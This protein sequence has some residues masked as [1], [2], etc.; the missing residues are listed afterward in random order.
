[1]ETDPSLPGVSDAADLIK[2]GQEIV[3]DGY[4]GIVTINGGKSL[5]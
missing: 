4:L 2:N 3:A 5:K 1:M